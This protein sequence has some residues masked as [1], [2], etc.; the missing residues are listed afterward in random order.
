M[1]R[2]TASRVTLPAIAI[3]AM[4]ALVVACRSI[5]DLDERPSLPP[6]EADASE[7]PTDAGTTPD[8]GPRFCST[9]TPKPEFCA[10]FEGPSLKE[11][12]ENESTVPDPGISN[13]GA[14]TPQL[15]DPHGGLRA[16]RF[17]VPTLLTPDDE[18]AAF[19]YAFAP[20][21]AKK[22]L[23]KLSLRI[24]TES[25]VPDAGGIAIL[26]S[27]EFGR[28]VGRIWISRTAKGMRLSV[29]DALKSVQEMEFSAPFPA[30]VWKTITILLSNYPLDAGAPDGSGADFGEVS[31]VVDGP[32][33]KLPVP[34]SYQSIVLDP[35]LHIGTLL[36]RGPMGALEVSMD[37]VWMTPLP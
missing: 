11:G 2:S 30:G 32:V 23:V 31:V 25:F 14:I 12:F 16:A 13:G 4:C 37:D 29:F 26:C 18:A 21:R 6:P 24:D 19:L 27:L 34:A 7:P 9:V 33:A 8:V 3:C 20:I 5:L 15:R 17:A 28:D 22:L 35:T 1:K 10:D 36:A